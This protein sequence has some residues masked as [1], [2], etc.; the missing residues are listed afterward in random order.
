MNYKIRSIIT[1]SVLVLFMV[2]VGVFINNI[3]G[4]VTGAVVT[5]ACECDENSDCDDGDVS[6]EDICLYKDNCEASICVNN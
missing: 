4:A 6:T 3:E 2:G 5:T 1:I